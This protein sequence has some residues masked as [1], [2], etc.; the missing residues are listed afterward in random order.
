MYEL[1]SCLTPLMNMAHEY[2]HAEVKST[3]KDR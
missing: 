2:S 1:K 3:K